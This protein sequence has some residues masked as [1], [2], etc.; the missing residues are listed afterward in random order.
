MVTSEKTKR[1]K[2]LNKEIKSH[3][4]TRMNKN[5]RRSIIPGNTQSLWT[6]VKVAKDTNTNVLPNTMYR[7][8]VEIEGADLAE[9]FAIIPVL[10]LLQPISLPSHLAGQQPWI[11]FQVLTN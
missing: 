11:K 9:N 5:V 3:F 2:K 1:I 6:A 4:Q 7:G 8:G 10:S